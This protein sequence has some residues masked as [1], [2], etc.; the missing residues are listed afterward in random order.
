MAISTAGVYLGYTAL[1]NI[2]SASSYDEIVKAEKEVSSW[3]KLIDITDYPDLISAP[4]R[5]ETTT[6]SNEVSRTYIADL[7]DTEAFTFGNNF[8]HAKYKALNTPGGEGGVKDENGKSKVFACCLFFKQSQSL[9]RWAAEITLGISGGGIS[10]VIKGSVTATPMTEVYFD[11]A[12]VG[13]MD[14]A[15]GAITATA[16]SK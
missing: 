4:E 10:E 1:S 5:I 13:T 7:R 12:K 8:E 14:E 9:I 16:S 6:L 2:S 15:T 3:K 11:Y